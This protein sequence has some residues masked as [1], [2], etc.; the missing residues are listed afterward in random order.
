MLKQSLTTSAL[1]CCLLYATVSAAHAA[2]PP[3]HPTTAAAQ[4]LKLTITNQ[5]MAVKRI[6]YRIKQITSSGDSW[7]SRPRTRTLSSSTTIA[8][9]LQANEHALRFEITK[10]W[11]NPAPQ[12][13][14]HWL[15]HATI[16]Q[17]AS[18]KQPAC[19]ST[20]SA[21]HPTA[22]LNFSSTRDSHQLQIA[23]HQGN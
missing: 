12:R 10:I 19:R 17:P 1:A 6:S 14:P 8:Q 22:Q 20:L 15:M 9:P 3:N 16:K 13:K 11:F 21:Q 2:T 23:C 4:A 18:I 5:H 7:L